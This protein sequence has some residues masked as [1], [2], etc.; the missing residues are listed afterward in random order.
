MLPTH[1]C[2]TMHYPPLLNI[3][4]PQKTLG[5]FRQER[6]NP[7][8]ITHTRTLRGRYFSLNRTYEMGAATALWV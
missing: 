5:T 6:I 4:A 7:M 8:Y 3:N 2:A 1:Y